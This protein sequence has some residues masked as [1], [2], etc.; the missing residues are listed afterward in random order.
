[1]KLLL[2]QLSS[3][4]WS[5]EKGGRY[6][7]KGC[8]SLTFPPILTRIPS[9]L[10]SECALYA[11]IHYITVTLMFSAAKI[12][13]MVPVSKYIY[14]YIYIYMD[15]TVDVSIGWNYCW[16]NIPVMNCLLCSDLEDR[17]IS[18]CGACRQFMREVSSSKIKLCKLIII[19]VLFDYLWR[20]TNMEL[21]CDL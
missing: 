16:F 13:K 5:L 18:P 6:I 7:L 15:L 17:F 9:N 20:H 21:Q 12:I 8:N 11:H 10:R 14:I 19:I 4:L 3:Y 2:S 1:M